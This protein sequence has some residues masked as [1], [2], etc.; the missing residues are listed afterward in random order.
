MGTNTAA[1]AGTAAAETAAASAMWATGTTQPRQHNQREQ[2][3]RMTSQ[4]CCH[5]ETPT[6]PPAVSGASQAAAATTSTWSPSRWWCHM[7]ARERRENE[8]CDPAPHKK[9]RWW[10]P[11]Y[12]QPRRHSYLVASYTNCA[13]AAPSR[14]AA[15]ATTLRS[16]A[17]W[18]TNTCQP[19]NCTAHPLVAAESGVATAWYR[20]CGYGGKTTKVADIIEMGTVN[21]AERV[22]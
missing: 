4:Y 19:A 13:L 15:P 20:K 12:P 17:L 1:A 11:N 6:W 16:S 7:R 8:E 5:C 2:H 18:A 21:N 3:A 10:Q 14:S 22:G 9:W